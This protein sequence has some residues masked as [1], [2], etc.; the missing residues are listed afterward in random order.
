[1]TTKFDILKMKAQAAL[2][3]VEAMYTL[4][5]NYIYGVGVDVNLV[6]AHSY[7]ENAASKGF[8]QAKE[9]MKTIFAEGGKS[10]ELEPKF[11][12]EGYEMLKTVCQAADKG[13]P[14]ALHLKSLS[15]LS[16]ETDN[17]RFYNAVKDMELACQQDYVPAL[18]SLGVVYYRGNRI[19]GMQQK[20][21]SM[22]MRAAEAGYIPAISEMMGISPEKVYPIIKKMSEKDDA[23]GEVLY[24]LSQYY[25]EGIVVEKDTEECVRLLNKAGE[26]KFHTAYFDLGILYE[27]GQYGVSRDI[28]KAVEYYEQ[29]VAL[30]DAEC[31]ISLGFI[32]ER[33]SEYPNDYKRAFELYSKAADE[34]NGMAFCNLGTCYKRGIGIEIDKGKAL[35]SYVKAAELKCM[36]A[37][38]NLYLYYMDGVCVPRDYDKAVEWL[39]KGD[40]AGNIQCTYQ[41]TK[42]IEN[43]DGIEKDPIR[44]LFYMNKAAIGGYP[45]AL[46]GLGNC[47]R[48]GIGTD[49]NGKLAFE[50]YQKAS[51]VSVEGITALAQCYTYGIGTQQD[52]DKAVELYK[53]AAEQG[54]AQAQCDL[55]IC[56]RSGEGVEKDPVKAIE[57]YLKAAEQGHGGA[58]NNLGIMYQHGIGVEADIEKAA[59]YYLK[60]AEAGNADGQFS[61]GLFYANGAGFDQ[62]YEEAVK[63]FSTAAHQGEPDSMFHLAK[64]YSEGLGVE[65]DLGMA[66]SLLYAAA[67]R[68]F[69]PAI[70]AIQKNRIPRP[71]N[72]TTN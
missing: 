49:A 59:M 22:I 34:E 14:A 60:A 1:M 31:M 12:E 9:L 28:A 53:M 58:L 54:D 61:V 62:N 52:Y 16:D 45:E 19:K 41:I 11:K 15:R 30:G 50:W 18:H 43:G 65:K 66:A 3:S 56:Y 64:L 5:V 25:R 8:V 70:D 36:E 46:V 2:G 35:D 32:L 17:F 67:D 10:V 20:G 38:W 33:S 57:W 29:G 21:L 23:E 71:N 47:Y 7:L 6:F 24:M 39:I 40:E 68:G 27:Y 63:W 51:Q 44:Y 55:G 37:Y 72:E 48:D 4:G 42:H 69:R 26:K 13:D